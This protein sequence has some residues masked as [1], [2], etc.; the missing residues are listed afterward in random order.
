MHIVENNESINT[1][2]QKFLETGH[3]H[4]ECDSM[5][6]T[7]ERRS[8][9]LDIHIPDGWVNV[10]KMARQNKPYAVITLKHTAFLNWQDVAGQKIKNTK[11]NTKGENVAWQKMRWIR[12]QKD[13][14]D[15]IR[16]KY[17]F[18]DEFRS[19]KVIRRGRGVVSNDTIIPKPCYTSQIGII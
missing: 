12:I 16:Y 11:V 18:D 4:L 15:H 2:D 5:H 7:I 6:S 1:I 17:G 3:T 8:K 19:I 14:P 9:G 10:I 13:D